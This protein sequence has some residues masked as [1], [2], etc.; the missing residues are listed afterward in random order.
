MVKKLQQATEQMTGAADPEETTFFTEVSVGRTVLNFVAILPSLCQKMAEEINL[1]VYMEGLSRVD[2]VV[3]DSGYA[4][5]ALDVIE[6]GL[7]S[8]EP[9][10]SYSHLLYVNV[11]KNQIADASPLSELQYLVCVDL[12]DN[13]LT[14]PPVLTQPYLQS[15]DL[16]GNKITST[17]LQGF[18]SG[19]ISVLKLNGNELNG[20]PGLQSLPSVTVLEAVGNAIEDL[21]SLAS[22]SAPK[23]EVLLLVS[24]FP[25]HNYMDIEHTESL[26]ENKITTLSGIESLPTL[27]SLSL[28]QNNIETLE[29]VHQLDQLPKLSS[30]NL[31]GNAVT[32]VEDY[33]SSI[34]LL[35]PTLTHL[36]GDQ[37]SDEDR[38]A[39][40]ELK[41]QREAEA[42][43]EAEANE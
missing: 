43:E 14:A 19:S 39:A 40:V 41:H 20:L 3:D 18:E 35:V 33:R 32:Q 25:I 2:R 36:D 37:L 7:V 23:L 31:I 27:T 1:Q 30:L 26:D 8:L 38:L 17:A 9:I 21:S 29:A 13:V 22:D 16:S 34:I 28:Q 12:S 5:T 15:L 6:K 11:S 10:K 4:F 24:G 42:A